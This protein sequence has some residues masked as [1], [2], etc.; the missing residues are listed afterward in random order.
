MFTASLKNLSAATLTI[1]R[2]TQADLPALVQME[3]KTQCSP[4][5]LT[6]FQEELLHASSR[7]LVLCTNQHSTRIQMGYLV[8]RFLFEECQVLNFVISFRYQNQGFGQLLFNHLIELAKHSGIQKMIL[9]VR[10]SNQTAIH[11]YQKWGFQVIREIPQFYSNA[12]TAKQMIL[13]LNS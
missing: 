6:S 12:D 5:S 7:F 11:L 9:E 2:A 4:W 10:A 13:F 8:T 3:S 1:Q